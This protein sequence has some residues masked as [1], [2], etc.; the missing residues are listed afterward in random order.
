MIR[1]W[2]PNQSRPWCAHLGSGSEISP[3]A[4]H[5]AGRAVR[6]QDPVKLF[7]LHLVCSDSVLPHI[8]NA[9]HGMQ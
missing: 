4:G 6:L 8:N 9:M 2:L 1:S 7:Y 3:C 5:T